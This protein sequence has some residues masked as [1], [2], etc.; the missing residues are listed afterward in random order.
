MKNGFWHEPDGDGAAPP[1][2]LSGRQALGV[3]LGFLLAYYLLGLAGLALQS[4]QTGVTPLWPAAGAAFALSFWFGTR[5]A[6]LILPAMLALALSVGLPWSVALI[7]ALGSV[8]EVAVPVLLLRRLGL[9]PALSNVRDTLLFVLAAAVLGPLFSATLGTYAMW[10][11]AGAEIRLANVWLLW[12]LGNSLGML[13]VGGLGLVLPFWR[14]DLQRPAAV[15]EL[16]LGLV[17][18]GLVVTAS[19]LDADQV[20]SALLMYLLVPAFLCLALRQGQLGVL[21]AGLVAMAT[22]LAVSGRMSE[23]VRD[24]ADLGLLFLDIMLLWLTVFTGMAVSAAFHERAAR[25]RLSWLA[26]HDP[27]TRLSNRHAFLG[28][29]ARA[30]AS[31]H[32]HGFE[33]ALI[34][35][36]LDNFKTVNDTEGHAAGDRLLAEL[37]AVLLGEVRGRDTVARLGGDEFAVLLEHC[38]RARSWRTALPRQPGVCRYASACHRPVPPR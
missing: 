29:L 21:G 19:G 11:L 5:Y 30:V 23:V 36:D 22:L 18:V 37:G 31:A 10:Q 14:R 27:L 15:A 32:R 4:A 33:H 28:R 34:Y 35:L 3:A 13:V 24:Q 17:L 26:G 20:Q 1:L 9:D 38:P 25:E 2:H 6:L 8:L 12:W 7:A 16:G